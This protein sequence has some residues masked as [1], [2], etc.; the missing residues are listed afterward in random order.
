[1][2]L[3]ID[4][5]RRLGWALL[6]LSTLVAFVLQNTIVQ[7]LGKNGVEWIQY[8]IVGTAL[9][10]AI[11]IGGLMLYEHWVWILRYP[12]LNYRGSRTFVVVA[13]SGD[14]AGEIFSRGTATIR[15]TALKIH[16]SGNSNRTPDWSVSNITFDDEMRGIIRYASE[17][18]SGEPDAKRALIGY[19][20]FYPR[21]AT[22]IA[23][24]DCGDKQDGRSNSNWITAWY[25]NRMHFTDRY[26]LVFDCNEWDVGNR[27]QSTFVAYFMK[28]ELTDT[29][30]Y[31]L[32]SLCGM[33]ADTVEH[34]VDVKANKS[35]RKKVTSAKKKSPN[36]R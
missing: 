15:Q 24:G 22:C 27:T 18:S 33:D 21:L 14:T 35:S 36:K 7:W 29:Q 28:Q 31:E 6:G 25:S 19:A 10:G 30:V 4:T 11:Y 23:L 5:Y 12:Y 20:R 1:M 16:L 8:V 13:T 2:N 26:A 3:L 32:H 9:Y 34:K 17:S